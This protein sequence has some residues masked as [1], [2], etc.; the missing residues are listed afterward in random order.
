MDW[1]I[2]DNISI[3]DLNLD[4]HNIRTPIS[5]KDQNALIRDMFANEDAFEIVKSYVQNGIFPDEFPI[6]VHFH[7]AFVN[8]RKND[9]VDGRCRV[10]RGIQARRLGR[11]ADH[12]DATLF[13]SR[14]YKHRC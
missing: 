2:E 7:Q 12:Q 6:V 9:P 8:V 10:G 3:V 11:L 4:Q 5:E 1:P 14:R 13:R